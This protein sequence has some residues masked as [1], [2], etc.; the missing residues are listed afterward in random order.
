ME[1]TKKNRS[2]FADAMK[3]GIDRKVEEKQAEVLKFQEENER[4]VLRDENDALTESQESFDAI[5]KKA[6]EKNSEETL[7]VDQIK[8]VSTVFKT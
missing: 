1:K 3:L 7:R 2:D 8:S 5:I 6:K 4:S